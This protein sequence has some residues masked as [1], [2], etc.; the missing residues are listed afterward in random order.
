MLSSLIFLMEE[1][2]P[3]ACGVLGGR[4][5]LGAGF[6]QDRAI[7][8]TVEGGFMPDPASDDVEDDAD[9]TLD[10]TPSPLL[11][12]FGMDEGFDSP[13][14]T[15]VDVSIIEDLSRVDLS[16]TDDLSKLV[17]DLSMMMKGFSLLDGPCLALSSVHRNG[18]FFHFFLGFKFNF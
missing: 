8:D 9:P 4:P 11:F 10:A 18:H 5:G 13:A 7:F 15:D 17:V 6:A 1:L 12:G 3:C 14:A 16:P 2:S